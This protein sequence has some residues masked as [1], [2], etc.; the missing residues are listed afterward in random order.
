[1][2]EGFA[3]MNKP[4]GIIAG[5]GVLPSRLAEALDDLG[6]TY[7]MVALAGISADE[8]RAQT[9]HILGM[10]AIGKLISLFKDHDVR[11]YVMVGPVTRPNLDALDLDEVGQELIE[12]FIAEGGGGDDALLRLITERL[13]QADLAI[14]PV[15]SILS[16][17]SAPIG[18]LSAAPA[19]LWQSDIEI[20]QSLL[21]RLSP[22]DV[23]QACIV[24]NGQVIAIEG[25]EGTDAMLAR[26][27]DILARRG[28]STAQG[29]LVK[30]P[31]LGQD[32]SV[33]LPTL[34]MTTMQGVQ[35]AGLAG[36]AFQGGGTLLID[37]DACIDF[38]NRHQLFVL[39]LSG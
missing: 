21:N 28:H 4:L 26:S 13:A 15:E 39:G 22:Y 36:I 33:D 12:K 37:R 32:R 3:K 18:V 27:A 38:A 25:P 31:K 24:Q 14:I 11:E 7:V 2:I 9:P 8:T 34:G 5:G 20:G 30:L 17:L 35:N 6:R 1:M 19:D 10:G 16:D 23:G 29:V